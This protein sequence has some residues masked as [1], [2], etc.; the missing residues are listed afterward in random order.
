MDEELRA[1]QCMVIVESMSSVKGRDRSSGVSRISGSRMRWVGVWRAGERV[2][3]AVLR[4]LM[5]VRC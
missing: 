3:E 2:G 4:V 5:G 1:A